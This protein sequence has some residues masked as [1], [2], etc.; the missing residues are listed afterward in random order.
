MKRAGLILV[1]VLLFLCLATTA[2]SLITNR[3]LPLDELN[4]PQLSDLD[5]IRLAEIFHLRQTLGNDAWPG[6]GD[7]EIPVI[8]YNKA[9][10]FLVGYP[11]EPPAGWIKVPQGDQ[12]GGAWQIVPGDDF[13]GQP[14]YRTPLTEDGPTPEAFTVQVGDQWVASLQIHPLMRVTMAQ[15][16]RNALPDGVR[17][18][19]P[20]TLVANLFLRNSDSYV[21]TVLHETFH[22][23]Q[24]QQ[25]P[26]RLV[27]AERAVARE[28]TYPNQDG[29]FVAAWQEELNLLQA[30]VRAKD[31]AET[32]VLAQQFLT[33]RD[34][35]RDAANLSSALINYERQREWQEGL[36]LYTE[37]AILRQAYAHADYQPTPG[38]ATDAEF[39][40]YTQFTRRWQQETDQITR[41][42]GNDG[43]G[44]FYYSGM[45]QA[46]ILDRLMPDW[47]TQIFHDDLFMMTPKN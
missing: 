29:A 39:D 20:Y 17:E 38:M 35:R 4:A 37:L 46:A 26:D 11:G 18:A 5:K 40:N 32:A 42:A 16:I 19:L 1:V 12:R 47:K 28:A 15:E 22:A 24:G 3:N 31:V 30:A 36:A 45:A 14:Y 25:V 6:W 43:D 34:T 9:Y 33:Q 7:A 44:R 8:L 27:A 2:V 21:A 10:A 23:Y 41:M 13:L